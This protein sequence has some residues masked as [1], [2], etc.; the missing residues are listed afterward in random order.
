MK[1]LMAKAVARIAGGVTLAKMVLV[2]PVLK[3]R[4]KTARKMKIQLAG[5]GTL[6]TSKI[7]GKAISILTPETR[8]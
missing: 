8:K 4:K 3:N 7:T 5:K 2:G 1:M 6:R